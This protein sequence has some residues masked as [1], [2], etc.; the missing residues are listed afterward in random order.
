MW[1]ASLLPT[2][3]LL[4]LGVPTKLAKAAPNPYHTNLHITRRVPPLPELPTAN[5]DRLGLTVKGDGVLVHY[6]SNNVDFSTATQAII[7][8]HGRQR[9]AVNH[10][11]GMQAAVEAVN[12]RNVVIMAVTS[13]FL[14]LKSTKLISAY[15]PFSSMG[16]IRVRFRGRTAKLLPIN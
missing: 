7:V 6:I 10:F 8:I 12:R 16:S 11:A 15:S 1:A 2:L 9:D 3:S 5:I 4:V 13:P 14:F